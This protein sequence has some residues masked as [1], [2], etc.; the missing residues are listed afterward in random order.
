MQDGEAKPRLEFGRGRTGKPAAP[1][2][3]RK[4]VPMDDVLAKMAGKIG[5]RRRAA[6]A[7]R[8]GRAGDELEGSDS[9]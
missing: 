2:A 4:H 3:A 7:S 9:A 1:P 5:E 8:V 6:E